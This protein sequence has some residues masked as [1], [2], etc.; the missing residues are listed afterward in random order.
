MARKDMKFHM[1][2]TQIIIALQN[3]KHYIVPFSKENN[4]YGVYLEHAYND[5]GTP[6]AFRGT[7][8]EIEEFLEGREIYRI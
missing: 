8:E 1:G 6:L 7:K 2:R 3:R 5:F 4:D